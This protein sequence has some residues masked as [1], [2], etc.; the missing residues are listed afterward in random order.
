MARKVL[1][2]DHQPNLI[3]CLRYLLEQAGLTVETAESGR[4]ALHRARE[5]VPEVVLLETHLPDMD[6]YAVYEQLRGIL[7]ANTS[8]LVVTARSREVDRDKA[9][10]LGADGYF[11]KPYDPSAVMRCIQAAA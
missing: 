1:V 2:V 11:A 8:I 9:L 7:G 10:A 6:G 5:T 3:L 4:E